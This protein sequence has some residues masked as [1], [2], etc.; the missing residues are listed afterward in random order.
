VTVDGPAPPLPNFLVIGSQRGGST[1]LH[2]Q[3]RAH[4]EVFMPP[5]EEG[6]FD[7]PFYLERDEAWLRQL[8]AGSD[9]YPARGFRESLWIAR[10]EC[11]ERIAHDLPGVRL[12]ASLREPVSRAVSTYF[13]YIGL[14]LAPV[15]PLNTGMRALLD[16]EWDARYPASAH[17]LEM[18]HYGPQLE[19]VLAHHDRDHFLVLVNEE[20]RQDPPAALRASY[21][22]IGVDPDFLPDA[23]EDATNSG[24]RR[25][26]RLRVR[27]SANRFVFRSSHESALGF[28]VKD[29]FVPRAFSALATR[30]EQK[31][32]SKVL[33]ERPHDLDPALRDELTRR[34]A[35]DVAAVE[36]HLGRRL[37]SWHRD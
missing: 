16:G 23:L 29:S 1:Y 22:F 37:P 36:E 13:H 35:D 21:E 3:L 7:D 14:G 9:A 30:F 12:L 8:F 10:P 31:V 25:L 5:R 18:G 26:G 27:R 2:K 15:V 32:V 17:V 11:P 28:Y 24:T 34:Y 33:T 19:R 4:P 20:I 6:Y